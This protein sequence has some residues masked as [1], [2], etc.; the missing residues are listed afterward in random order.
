M[1]KI[2]SQVCFTLQDDL[3]ERVD[4]MA[5]QVGKSRGE[6][7]RAMIECSLDGFEALM[8]IKVLR[9]YMERTNRK[10]LIEGRLFEEMA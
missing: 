6:V 4:K 10:E 5:Q 8:K 9:K 2:G 3:R 7:L 1:Q